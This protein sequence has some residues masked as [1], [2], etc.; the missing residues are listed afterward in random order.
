MSPL[1]HTG[2][3]CFLLIVNRNCLGYSLLFGLL[4]ER[5]GGG[6]LVVS[7]FGRPRTPSTHP[8]AIAQ[9]ESS[10]LWLFR[11]NRK[12]IKS[13]S[14]CGGTRCRGKGRSFVARQ[15]WI[16]VIVLTFSPCGLSVGLFNVL[17]LQVSCLTKETKMTY[18][19][20][21]VWG[22]EILLEA[23]LVSVLAHSRHAE[24]VYQCSL[25]VGRWCLPSRGKVGKMLKLITTIGIQS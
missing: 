1:I 23:C 6:C 3:L 15:T 9:H 20:E 25:S 14:F 12:A 11:L 10:C 17:E 24:S 18:F 2:N 5:C 8:V 7:S 19:K 13:K 22:S 21:L 16:R 4:G